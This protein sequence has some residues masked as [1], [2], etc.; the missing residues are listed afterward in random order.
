LQNIIDSDIQKPDSVVQTTGAQLAS[1]VKTEQ[2]RSGADFTIMSPA[3]SGDIDSKPTYR[4]IRT[5]ANNSSK[6]ASYFESV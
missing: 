5:V 4:K 3:T 1:A 6:H 2:V